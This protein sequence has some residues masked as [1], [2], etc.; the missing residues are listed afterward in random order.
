[1]CSEKLDLSLDS[2][3]ASAKD[4]LAPV[5][6]LQK[7]NSEQIN[8]ERDEKRYST[9]SLPRHNSQNLSFGN[10]DRQLMEIILALIVERK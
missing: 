5:K 10:N 8:F 9:N 2:P 6:R 1:M 4:V 3:T 7:S